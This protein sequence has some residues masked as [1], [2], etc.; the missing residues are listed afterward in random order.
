[1]PDEQP[2]IKIDRVMRFLG[3]SLLWCIA[4]DANAQVFI[5]RDPGI[6]NFREDLGAFDQARTRPIEDGI[7][8]GHDYQPTAHCPQHLPS[9]IRVQTAISSVIFATP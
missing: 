7:A 6:Q 3:C 1:M 8:I 2:V 9:C 5:S 4:H